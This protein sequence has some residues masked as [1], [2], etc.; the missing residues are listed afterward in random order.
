MGA[1]DLLLA[2]VL[3]TRRY[4]DSSLIVELFT[5]EQGRVP[6]VAKGV[7]RRRGGSGP[8]QPFASLLVGVQGRGEMRTL[9]SAEPSGPAV[10]LAGRRLFC[11]LYLNE[12]LTYLTVRHDPCAD[13]FD[14]YV[15]TLRA[16]EES[17]E[18]EPVLRRFE[19]GMLRHL[20]HAPI[21]DEDTRGQPISAESRYTYDLERGPAL[22]DANN[23][24]SVRGL[25]L[26]ALARG[27]FGDTET[28]REARRFM[29][30][31]INH[32]LEGRPLRSR[33]L[34]R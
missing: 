30:R 28:L 18:E 20:G 19:L 7:L 21:L 22:T 32:R 23:P 34:F 1:G 25:T 15:S 3:H 5:R 29:R 26:Q 13:L 6:C 8:P 11:G 12:L 33:E 17:V 4:R 10:D 24:E 31:I 9:V 27:E 14:D 2:F 16:L